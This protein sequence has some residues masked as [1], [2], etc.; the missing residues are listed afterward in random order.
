MRGTPRPRRRL[1]ATILGVAALVAGLA[2]VPTGVATG[3]EP[4]MIQPVDGRVSGIVDRYCNQTPSHHKG[5]DISGGNGGSVIHAA[6]SGRVT[7]TNSN[8]DNSGYGNYVIVSH[9][10]GWTTL[11]AHMRYAPSVG[12]GD[13]VVQGQLLGY[14]GTTGRST[15]NHLHFEISRNGDRSVANMAYACGQAVYAGQPIPMPFPGIGTGGA[16][17]R[18]SKSY[19]GPSTASVVTKRSDGSVHYH[20][21]D[22]AGGM[23]SASRMGNGWSD[24]RLIAAGG[25]YNGDGNNDVF[26]IAS[27]G[28]LW[29]YNGNGSGAFSGRTSLGGGFG[30]T[31][32]FISAGDFTN[33]G[34]PDIVTLRTDGTLWRHAGSRNGA[35]GSPQQMATGINNITILA[36]GADYTGDGNPDILALNRSGDLLLYPGN[37]AGGVGSPTNLGREWSGMNAIVGGMDFNGDGRADLIARDGSGRVYLYPGFG[38]GTFGSRIQIASGWESYAGV[39]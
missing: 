4:T 5:I 7:F 35:L 12:A 13:S 24:M 28:T 33:D 23:R 10:G 26:G 6:A 1:V 9:G 22:G 11:Y 29:R 38:N 14:V 19:N 18:S 30:S 39:Y 2:V 8:T 25:D 17:A 36:G 27:N 15:G 31:A 3:F 16:W 34:I 32:A 20:P 37:G 21:G